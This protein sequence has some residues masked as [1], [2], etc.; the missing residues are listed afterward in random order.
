[1][2]VSLVVLAVVVP[3]VTRLLLATQRVGLEVQATSV[4]YPRRKAPLA[5]TAIWDQRPPTRRLVLAVVVAVRVP[6]VWMARRV[7]VVPVV[8]VWLGT[9]GH[10]PQRFTLVVAVEPPTRRVIRMVLVGLVAVVTPAT[11]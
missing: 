8:P 4:V 3:L 10:Q 7:R 1:M 11:I 5:V 6:P 2:L 9:V